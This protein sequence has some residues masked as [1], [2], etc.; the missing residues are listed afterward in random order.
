MA[1][2]SSSIVQVAKLAGVSTAT[3]SRVLN[4]RNIVSAETVAKVRQAMKRA[5]YQPPPPG[6]RRGPKAHLHARLQHRA[7][8]FLWVGAQRTDGLSGD[9]GGGNISWPGGIQPSQTLTGHALLQGAAAALRR[10][11][12]SIT[13]DY[14]SSADHLPSV[15]ENRKV[16]GVLLH[17]PQ[18]DERLAAVLREFP[19]VWLLYS[20]AHDWGDRVQPDHRAAGRNVLDYFVGQKCRQVCCITY[21]PKWPDNRYHTERANAFEQ[22]ARLRQIPVVTLGEDTDEPDSSEGLFDLAEKLV[23]QFARLKPRPDALFVANNL[24][25]YVHE[26]L[27]RRGIEPMQDVLYVAGDRE[28]VYQ[29]ME[30]APIKV[31]I[32]SQ[33]IGRLAVELLIMRLANRD[34][35]RATLM[36]EPT[37]IIPRS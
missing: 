4:E 27:R 13:V 28:V 8:A 37:L 5:G 25:Y 10:H 24:G 34:A 19:A 7:I 14:L 29:H 21:R 33:Q 30:P 32:H 23:E 36:V 20:G 15:I 31:D 26:H 2:S 3:V 18:P 35:P 6:A 17:G 22:F 11:W 1:S 16:D 12:V 9:D